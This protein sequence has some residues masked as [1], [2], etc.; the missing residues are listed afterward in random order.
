VVYGP[1]V[2]LGRTKNNAISN[3]RRARKGRY[4]GVSAV[5]DNTDD[6]DD[7]TTRAATESLNA[8]HFADSPHKS[9]ADSQEISP[10]KAGPSR[11]RSEPRTPT[12]PG[13]PGMHDRMYSSPSAGGPGMMYQQYSPDYST[14]ETPRS[15]ARFGRQ[16]KGPGM[17]GP[18]S[19]SS[20]RGGQ[21]HVS[22][23][24]PLNAHQLQGSPLNGRGSSRFAGGQQHE[25]M[26]HL[27]FDQGFSGDD[28][29]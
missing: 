27:D 18:P 16:L 14:G 1:S 5:G 25:P 3:D 20:M 4:S 21:P 28:Q 2:I 23:N 24:T 13:R 12:N 11:V 7:G 29:N 22:S 8:P 10:T 15:S 6:G 26:P 9:F 17:M 19:A